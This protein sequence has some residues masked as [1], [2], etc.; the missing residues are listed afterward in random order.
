MDVIP[1]KA[2]NK[3]ELSE[4]EIEILEKVIKEHVRIVQLN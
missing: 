3:S 2:F 4:Y 1:L